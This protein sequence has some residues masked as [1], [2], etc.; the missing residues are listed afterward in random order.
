MLKKPAQIKSTIVFLIAFVFFF[1]N[2]RSGETGITETD[3]VTNSIAGQEIDLDS[4]IQKNKI[5]IVDFYSEYC[6]PCVKIAPMLKELD[7]KREDIAVI[8]IDINR[9]DIKGIDWNSPV[10]KQFNLRSIPYFMIYDKYGN[11]Q[12]EGQKAYNYVLDILKEEKILN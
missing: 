11:M 9:P 3:K 8:K 5:N 7:K 10:S 4:L 1:S 12:Y 2:C 6:P